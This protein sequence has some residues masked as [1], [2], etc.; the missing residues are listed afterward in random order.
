MPDID[1]RRPIAVTMGD[2]AGVGPEVAARA[3]AARREY[4]LPPFVAIGDIAAIEAVWDGPAVRV[5][6]MEEVVRAFDTALPVWHLEDSGPLTPGSP[7]PAGAT[8]ALHALETGIGLTRN[9]ASDAL[10]TGSV[11]KHALHGIGYTHP[12]QTEFIAERCG[13]T[14]T[15]AVMMLAG[16]ALRVVPL[17]VHIPLSEVPER[18]TAD[19]IAAKARIVARGLSRDFGIAAPRLAIAGLNPH[20]GE[21]GQLG[22]EE[23]RIIAPA[24]AQLAGEGIAIDGPLAADALFAPGI[25]DQYHAILCCYHD[26]ALAPFK[27]LHFHDG[28]NLTL[29]LPIIRTSPD[30]GTAFDIAGTGKAD[31]GP[32]IAAIAMA[33]QMAT[34]RERSSAPAK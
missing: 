17:T 15:N 32:T 11:S 6:A 7:T 31:P 19:L 20:A 33:A 4:G 2:P 25:R 26:Q 27:A 30:H 13:V 9:G 8:C 3:W 14:A 23:I 21:S 16:P 5:G 18:L 22:D 34:A 1:E 10:V 29:G 12:G 24:V 28:V